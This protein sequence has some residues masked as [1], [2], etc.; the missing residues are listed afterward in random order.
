VRFRPR[1]AAHFSGSAFSPLTSVFSAAGRWRSVAELLRLSRATRKRRRQTRVR[2][3][4]KIEPDILERP[5]RRS[6]KRIGTSRTGIPR[7]GSVGHLD[8]E[9]VAAGVDC[10]HVDALQG[11]GLPSLE[12]GRQIVNPNTQ[13]HARVDPAAAAD[14]PAP[15]SPVLV[16]PR[17]RS[18]THGHVRAFFQCLQ[19]A[20]AH[21][22]DCA[23]NPRPSAR[24]APSPPPEPLRKPACTR[25]PGRPCA[26]CAARAPAGRALRSGRPRRR[27]RRASCRRL[28]Q[29]SPGAQRP[30]RR[31][32]WVRRIHARCRSG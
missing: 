9:P 12:P 8:L 15:Q 32:Q 7:A 6:T 13:G 2:A 26:S 24:C 14:E 5:T 28:S 23:R 17:A 10:P 19:P 31:Q 3:S 30:A 16:P 25:R 20:A 22:P 21:R 1:T 11:R 29:W 27:S 4:K 18:A